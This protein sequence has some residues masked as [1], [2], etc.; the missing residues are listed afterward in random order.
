MG[1]VVVREGK[2]EKNEKLE[3]QYSIV[4][5]KP[6]CKLYLKLHSSTIYRGKGFG[7]VDDELCLLK[8]NA[9]EQSAAVEK[10]LSNLFSLPTTNHPQLQKNVFILFIFKLQFNMF[11][12]KLL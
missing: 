10:F 5:L 6:C 7:N 8:L 9:S 3:D 4:T 1:V 12:I 11:T 2:L